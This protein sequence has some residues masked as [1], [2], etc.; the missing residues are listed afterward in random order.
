MNARHI[1]SALAIWVFAMV[2]ASR[3][4]SAF[5]GTTLIIEGNGSLAAAST[6]A[7]CWEMAELLEQRGWKIPPMRVRVHK[8]PFDATQGGADLVL[9]SSANPE[10]NAVLFVQAALTRELSQW[11]SPGVAR[12]LAEMTAVKLA[13]RGA[14]KPMSWQEQWLDRL[15]SGDI[16]T[17]ALPEALWRYG[18]DSAVRAAAR[19]VWPD[20]AFKVLQ[21]LREDPLAGVLGEIAIAGLV[22][23]SR[24][25]F[26]IRAR[27]VPAILGDNMA[28]G[29]EAGQG[30]QLRLVQVHSETGAAAVEVLRMRGMGA[31][32]VVR[33]G[34]SHGFDVVSLSPF[35]EV[36]VPLQGAQWAAV[37]VVSIDSSGVFSLNTRPVDG[38]PL[39]LEEWDFR[40]GD[41]GV[42]LHWET[43]THSG[44]EAFLIE[45]LG[46]SEEEGFSVLRRTVVPVADE[47]AR[48]WG[49]AFADEETDG[50]VG[51]RLLAMTDRGLL[52]EVGMFPVAVSLR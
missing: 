52:A 2:G 35:E 16:L 21:G 41:A 4:T 39:V 7:A 48:P 11:T 44:L 30:P 5:P 43:A 46:G 1:L 51:Y 50:V 33:Y 29:A 32:L 34:F 14:L 23:P 17:T 38:F 49:Y 31:W 22:D 8:D 9:S 37:V 3:N 15:V 24:L 12:L 26:E 10:D 18:G 19:G 27:A 47:G 20:Q 36:F 13:P 6:V 28:L 42:A 45:A 40:S 25:G